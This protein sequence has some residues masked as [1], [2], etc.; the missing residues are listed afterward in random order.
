[1][2]VP[3]IIGVFGVVAAIGLGL[4]EQ[5]PPAE[6]IT[7]AAAM[8]ALIVLGLLGAWFHVQSNLTAQGTFVGERFLRGA[9]SLAPLLF[10]NMGTIGL[11]A[12]L[13]PAEPGWERRPE[14][15]EALAS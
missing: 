5:P 10:A 3:T 8:A 14:R 7:Y 12:L 9:P 2:W 1:L 4:M 11:L 13:D 6:V 15:A